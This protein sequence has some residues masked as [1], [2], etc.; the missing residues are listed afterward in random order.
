MTRDVDTAPRT[1]ERDVARLVPLVAAAMTSQSLLVV[2]TPSLVAVAT[3]LGVEV[4]AAGQARSLTGAV[5]LAGALALLVSVS[6]FGVRRLA[7]AGAFLVLAASASVATATGPIHYLVAH[8]PVGLA[9]AT[10]LTAGFAGLGGFTGGSRAWAAGWVTAAHGFAWVI[11]GP[12]SGALTEHISWRA[13]HVFPAILALGVLTLAGRFAG[14]AGTVSRGGLANMPRPAYRWV[15]A[16]TLAY[17]G[18]AGV[19]TYVGALFVVGLG[20]TEGLTGW[21]L[22]AG[23]VSFV[24]ASVLGGRLAAAGDLRV[25]VYVLS[26]L[27]A[28]AVAGVLGTALLDGDA[29]PRWLVGAVAY[30]M[31]NAIAGA[32]IA[33]TNV[34]GMAQHPERPE[35]MMTALAG[36]IQ[37]G[38]LLGAVLSGLALAVGDWAVSGLVLALVIA[39]SAV[40][41]ALRPSPHRNEP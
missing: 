16:E 27:L 15:V 38:Y 33:T 7:V 4:A 20:T 13:T 26:G 3:D 41:T 19:L 11:G 23:A 36:A 8:V 12:I 9:I 6:S 35:L 31:A 24:I 5:A 34:L 10:L 17:M 28:V 29:R 32:R 21:V 30:A 1:A 18:W 40:L 14:P 25:T 2:L 37:A 22:S 39:A